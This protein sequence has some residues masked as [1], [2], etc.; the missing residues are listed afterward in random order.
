ML[1]AGLPKDSALARSIN[2]DL[3]QWSATDELLAD[4]IEVTDHGN[5][6]FFQAHSAEGTRQPEPLRVRRPSDREIAAMAQVAPAEPEAPRMATPGE[7]KA[8]FGGDVRYTPG[9]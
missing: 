8:F 3:S 2:S 5:R 1:A 7:M 4:L 9:G 6:L